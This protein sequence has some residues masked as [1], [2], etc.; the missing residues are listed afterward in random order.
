MAQTHTKVNKVST[1]PQ[2]NKESKHTKQTKP[3]KADV[4]VASKTKGNVIIHRNRSNIG[5]DIN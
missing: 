1:Y 2:N 5:D 4:I 3:T